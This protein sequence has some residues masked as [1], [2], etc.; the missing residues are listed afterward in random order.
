M[1]LPNIILASKSPRRRELLGK[2]YP[3]FEVYTVDVDESLECG[4]EIKKGTEL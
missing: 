4:T 1:S 3:D 2:L